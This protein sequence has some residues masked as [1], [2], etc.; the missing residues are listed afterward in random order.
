MKKQEEE[1]NPKDI[2]DNFAKLSSVHA[3]EAFLDGLVQKRKEINK[4]AI[5]C[6][7]LKSV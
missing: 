2:K 3:A 5:I 7:K 4:N 6:A 1:C